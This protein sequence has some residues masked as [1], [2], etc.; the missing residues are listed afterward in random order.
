[1][2]SCE[3][4]VFICFDEYFHVKT[5]MVHVYYFASLGCRHNRSY[6]PSLGVFVL[7]WLGDT[8]EIYF[9]EKK[10]NKESTPL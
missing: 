3:T 6:E 1:M 7:R 5:L 9:G 8:I 2:V 10:Q 4:L